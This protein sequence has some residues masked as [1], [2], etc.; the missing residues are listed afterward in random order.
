M[1]ARKN[2]PSKMTT[3]FLFGVIPSQN[4]DN[5]MKTK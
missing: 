1:I 4:N 2:Q 5:V 3:E